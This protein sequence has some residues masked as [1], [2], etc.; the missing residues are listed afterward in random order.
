MTSFPCFQVAAADPRERGRQLGFAAKGLI[1]RTL[2]FYRDYFNDVAALQWPVV[3]RGAREFGPVIAAY[4]EQIMEEIDGIA[5]GADLSVDDV[6][7]INA[8]T[9]LMFGL[10]GQ[11]A[12][13]CTAFYVGPSASADGHVLLGQNWDYYPRASA[14]TIL[15]EVEQGER[16]APR[17]AQPSRKDRNPQWPFRH[18]QRAD[19]IRQPLTV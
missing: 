8:R 14:S 6:L 9:E 16:R 2:E 19:P 12:A 7:A 17:R 18:L 4:D 13:E 11:V 3:R 1:E 5:E 15:V 10:A